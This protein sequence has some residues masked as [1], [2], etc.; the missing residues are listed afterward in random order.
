MVLTLDLSK[1][2]PMVRDKVID[3]VRD[4][5]YMLSRE[6]S[7]IKED[8]KHWEAGRVSRKEEKS[9]SHIEMDGWSE[10]ITKLGTEI[11]DQIV[12]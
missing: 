8:L 5:G 7:I 4:I 2:P 12:S 6:E 9:L 10:A 3:K 11:H 1:L